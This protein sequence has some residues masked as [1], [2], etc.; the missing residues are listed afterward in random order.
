M[1]RN[2]ELL[3]R[4]EEERQ[5]SPW[6]LVRDS[7]ALD[8]LNTE[9]LNIEDLNAED[10]DAEDLRAH[11][12]N[13]QEP[14]AEDQ[15]AA[16]T[17]VK[18]PTGSLP[19]VTRNQLESMLR[20]ISSTPLRVLTFCGVD[21]DSDASLITACEAELLSKTN[22][23]SVCVFDA[24]S[25]GDG[26]SDLF[27]PEK[28][29]ENVGRALL[30]T[31]IDENLWVASRDTAPRSASSSLGMTDLIAELRD[32][33][34]RVLVHADPAALS[35]ETEAIG[36]LSDGLILVI[37]AEFTARDLTQQVKAEFESANIKVLGAVL[38]NCHSRIPPR[39]NDWLRSL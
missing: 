20:K 8:D 1:S 34:N 9:D 13:T 28:P 35:T 29:V 25:V 33:F 14:K 19:S 7:A 21:T 16:G 23:G 10:L 24:S 39:L 38:N 32:N 27:G 15:K 26:V 17:Q 4:M 30:Y 18:S 36:Q 31:R 22:T 6:L 3:Q 11:D 5:K 12:R 2:F 37:E